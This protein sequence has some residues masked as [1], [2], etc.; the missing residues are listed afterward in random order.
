MTLNECTRSSFVITNDLDSLDFRVPCEML[1][2]HCQQF[3]VFDM[4]WKARK[5]S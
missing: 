5:S 2:E 4:G 1:G 3:D